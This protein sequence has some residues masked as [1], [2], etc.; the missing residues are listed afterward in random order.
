VINKRTAEEIVLRRLNENPT[1]ESP[2]VITKVI[3]QE[4]GWVFLYAAKKYLETND[5]RY[6]LAG[7]GPAVVEKEDGAIYFLGTHKRP[8]LLIQEY[9][10]RRKAT[11]S[12]P[13][14]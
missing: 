7:G 5:L 3:D 13:S 9:D 1:A 4:Y 11:K 2:I 14:K 6:L 10:E 12:E 8:E